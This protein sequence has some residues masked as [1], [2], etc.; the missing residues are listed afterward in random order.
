M[1]LV[2][3]GRPQMS[4][5]ERPG[6]GQSYATGFAWTVFF[7]LLTKGLVPIAGIV[8]ARVLGPTVMGVFALLQTILI[9]CDA[10]R[11]AG[12]TLA[13]LNEQRMSPER[14]RAF[15][16][17]G[18]AIGIALGG[19]LLL[20][21]APLEGFFQA[22]GLAV[23]MAWTAI[24]VACASFATVPLAKLL[25]QQR[26][27]QA[28]F[29]DAVATLVSY[30]IAL[31]MVFAGFGLIAL[32]AQ[33][34]IRGVLLWGIA[35][36][37]APSGLA[38]FERG[39]IPGIVRTCLALTGS[40]LLSTFYLLADQFSV[41]KLFGSTVNG[42]Y[43]MAKW[44]GSRP[45]E[46]VAGPLVKTSQVAFGHKAGDTGLLRD[47]MYKGMAAFVLVVAPLQV[48]VAV[49][50][51][52]LTLG[53]LGPAYAA[54]VPFV[55]VLSLYSATRVFG[56][57]AGSALVASGRPAAPMKCWLV[58][59]ATFGVWIVLTWGSL[60]TLQLTWLFTGGLVLVNVVTLVWAMAVLPATRRAL[61]RLAQAVLVTAAT[62]GA[63]WLVASLPLAPWPLLG[64]ALPT[65]CI[66]HWLA[67]GLVFA[68]NPIALRNKEALRTLY[69]E[70]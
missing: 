63:A 13:Y 35:H 50:A 28:G 25:R 55:A 45:A 56:P 31:G 6:N 59:Y 17:I 57:F 47:A 37:M 26:F 30:A 54:S 4:T 21:A 32:A 5:P 23:A 67:A 44:L 1:A 15:H 12:L 65:L 11:D 3:S 2:T 42:L 51:E 22:E 70:L 24:G 43:G 14:E 38:G 60:D 48:A 52:P 19:L 49:L 36:A 41:Q 27:K 53:L 20:A 34:V 46:F 10:F 66:A 40:N 69:R 29:A 62:T 18:V 68:R 58:G 33:I 39:A 16:V 7:G 8:I 64:V 9:L 61:T